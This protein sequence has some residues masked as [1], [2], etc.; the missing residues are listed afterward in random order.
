MMADKKTGP[1]IQ[2][3][4]TKPVV[5]LLTSI[6][7]E[8]QK[9]VQ[10]KTPKPLEGE[11]VRAV[12]LFQEISTALRLHPRPIISL[13]NAPPQGGT[14]TLTWSSTN[15]QTVSIEQEVGGVTTLLGE[16]TPASGGSKAFSGNGI[17]KF[18]ATAK[19]PCASATAFVT[20]TLSS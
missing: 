13:T 9:Q 11:A 12:E 14:V 6:L 3:T 20:V 17:T 4:E 5:D 15:A 18:T 7:G 2:D 16:L 10:S 1:G 19:G 8:V